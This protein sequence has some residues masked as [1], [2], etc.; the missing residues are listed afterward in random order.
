MIIGAVHGLNL[1]LI[2]F[3]IRVAAAGGRDRR[4]RSGRRS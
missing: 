4:S 1:L 3:L 2:Y